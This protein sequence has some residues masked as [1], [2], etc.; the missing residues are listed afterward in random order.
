MTQLISPNPQ[1]CLAYVFLGNENKHYSQ[2]STFLLLIDPAA[3]PHDSLGHGMTTLPVLICEDH[4]ET[5]ST[6]VSSSFGLVTLNNINFK[7]AML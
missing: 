1:S 7:G 3:P 4:K 5:P 2:F 6:A